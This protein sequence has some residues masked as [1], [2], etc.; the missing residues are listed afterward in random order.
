MN[1]ITIGVYN[2]NTYKINIVKPDH[3][4]S[5]VEY[6]K[7]FRPGRALFVDGKCVHSG[8]LSEQRIIEWEDKIKGMEIDSSV[9]SEYYD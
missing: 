7:I 9:A 1:H 6:N 5:H 2:N 4:E 8:Y 3:L